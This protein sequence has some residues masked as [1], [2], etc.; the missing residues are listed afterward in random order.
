MPSYAAPE[1]MYKRESIEVWRIIRL[2]LPLF[3]AFVGLSFGGIKRSICLADILLLTMFFLWPQICWT[4]NGASFETQFYINVPFMIS[5]LTIF[6]IS[7]LNLKLLKNLVYGLATIGTFLVFYR[8]YG[9]GIEVS[10]FYFRPRWT[11]GFSHPLVT[12]SVVCCMAMAI[13]ILQSH[14]RLLSVRICLQVLTLALSIY[15]LYKVDSKNMSI[16]AVNSILLFAVLAVLKNRVVIAL[17]YVIGVA[18]IGCFVILA[19]THYGFKDVVAQ[20]L[21]TSSFLSRLNDFQAIIDS[22][23]LGPSALFGV[24]NS[25]IKSFAVS[26]SIYTSIWHHYGL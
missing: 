13:L 18:S 2:I 16:F 11:F 25:V 8:I 23:Q 19:A 24:S 21:S 14:I 6:F 4:M 7:F 3:V 10:T 1:Q 12:S 20:K 17:S 15:V 5:G 22:I 26:D 9:Y